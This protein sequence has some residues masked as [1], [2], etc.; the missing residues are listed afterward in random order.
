[1]KQILYGLKTF[2]ILGFNGVQTP[3]INTSGKYTREREREIYKNI[4]KT[5]K[6]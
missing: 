3:T 1:M 4:F 2:K 6:R 5:I